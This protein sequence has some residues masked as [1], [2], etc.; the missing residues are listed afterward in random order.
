MGAG[1][2]GTAFALV[3]ADAGCRVTLWARRPE[4][5]AEVRDR[6]TN[7]AYLGEVVLPD[8][9]DATADAAA[10]LSGADLVVLAVPL[11]RLR[12]QLT[13]WRARLPDVPLVCL[14]KG[15]EAGT[16]LFG[17]EV[18]ADVTGAGPERLVAVSGP[19]LAAEIARREPA[20]TVVACADAA[21]AAR[22]AAT[23]TSPALRAEPTTDVLGVDVA[24][25][26]KNVVALAVGVV[27]GAGHGAN[28]RAAVLTRGLAETTRLGLALG[29]DAATFAGLAGIGDLV[30]TCGS[31][32]SRNHRAGVALGRGAPLVEALAAA[33]G[34]VEG[35]TSAPA[36][37]RRAAGAGVAAPLVEQVA[38][39]VAAGRAPDGLVARLVGA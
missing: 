32:L 10:A 34:T 11:Q 39:A 38:A 23:C 29:A 36:V 22:L 6:R 14:A 33:G 28:A 18:V 3:L 24:G 12:E 35:V 5:A 27:E 21:V 26:V 19:N 37:L 15:V 31:P 1:A 13:A 17:T 20:A 30:A 4:L 2:W 16:G 8:G 9:V 7:R 25:A